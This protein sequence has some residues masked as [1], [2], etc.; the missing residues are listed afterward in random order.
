MI[1][2]FCSSTAGK[3][4]RDKFSIILL[5]LDIFSTSLILN[6]VT[7]CNFMYGEQEH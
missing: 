6:D 1:C 4:H 3:I 2:Y 7:M 5:K